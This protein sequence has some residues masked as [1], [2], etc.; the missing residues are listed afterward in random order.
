V[1]AP[2]GGG[3]GSRRRTNQNWK[4]KAAGWES[5]GKVRGAGG[6][7]Q[8]GKRRRFNSILGGPVC[9]NYNLGTIW[10]EKKEG[11]CHHSVSNCKQTLCAGAL[12]TTA[13]RKNGTM[14]QGRPSCKAKKRHPANRGTTSLL[15]KN[16]K[17]SCGNGR[18]AWA[19]LG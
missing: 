3:V 1:T 17:C 4:T 10:G 2:W 16:H 19:A 5:G 6:S 13:N 9:Q 8:Q 11:S 15:E 12:N 7:Y 14:E 18:T